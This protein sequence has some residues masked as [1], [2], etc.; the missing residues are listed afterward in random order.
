MSRTVGGAM[1]SDSDCHEES[2]SKSALSQFATFATFT[3]IGV[4]LYSEQFL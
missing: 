4:N 3:T 1:D 2:T